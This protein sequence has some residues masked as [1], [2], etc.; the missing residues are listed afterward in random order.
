M[1]TI[2]KIIVHCS[3]TPAGRHVTT[4]DIDL[5]HQQRGFDCIGYHYVVYLDGS[6]H[7]G[8]PEQR[9]GAHCRGYN[10][11]SIGVCYI[12][13]VESDGRT[14]ADTRT[15]Q[16]KSALR[17]L[18]MSLKARYAQAVIHS[19]SDFACKACPSF[20]ATTEYSDISL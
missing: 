8:R 3:A 11:T 15:P 1:R 9:I 18:L 10:A 16:Q 14:P 6:V 20:D 2:N 17:Q 19:H 4:A 7:A 13:G 12:G 5:W